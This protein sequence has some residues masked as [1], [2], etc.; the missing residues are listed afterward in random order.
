M[1]YNPA[2]HRRR[3]IR[4]QGYDYGQPGLY[5]LTICT[6]GSLY[7]FGEI[8][9][10]KMV[11]NELGDIVELVWNELSQ[12]YPCVTPMAFVTMPNHVHG[13]I[14]VGAQ[15]SGRDE[16][17][18]YIMENI[19]DPV[20]AQFIAPYNAVTPD[21]LKIPK[22]PIGEIVRGFKARCTYAINQLRQTP[23][24]PVWQR[25]YHD[26]II[27]DEETYLKITE[28][29]QTNPLRWKEDPYYV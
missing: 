22:T 19:G 14:H 29:I 23:G 20:G 8:I 4:L 24:V 12:H 16:S 13:I 5:F 28:Y 1:T 10:Q 6:A 17:R 11:P 2:I 3:S 15:L 18:P 7:I 26:H 9:N 25:N 27:R 21:A